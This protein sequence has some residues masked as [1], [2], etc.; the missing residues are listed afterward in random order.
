MFN[1]FNLKRVN[2]CVIYFRI[3]KFK[4]LQSNRDDYERILH[5]KRRVVLLISIN[6]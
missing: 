5:E 1:F 6:L 4:I 2:E 3:H